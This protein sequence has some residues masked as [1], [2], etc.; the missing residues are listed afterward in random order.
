MRGLEQVA[1]PRVRQGTAS[2]RRYPSEGQE[3]VISPPYTI[4][5]DGPAAAGRS[6]ALCAR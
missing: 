3:T 4:P 6:F 5:D 1:D 2:E